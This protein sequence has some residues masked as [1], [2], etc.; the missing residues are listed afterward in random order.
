M[1][2][3]RTTAP[4]SFT[5]S[6]ASWQLPLGFAAELSSAE[7]PAPTSTMLGPHGGAT[8]VMVDRHG[9]VSPSDKAWSLDWR[10]RTGDG[11]ESAGDVRKTTQR[12]AGGCV[13]E[14]TMPTAVG[15]IHHRVA[16]AVAGGQPVVL[17]DIENAA[18]VAVAVALAVRPFSHRHSGV[19]AIT[20][21]V[22]GIEADGQSALRPLRPPLAVMAASDDDVLHQLPA[23][24]DTGTTHPQPA[25]SSAGCA[26][27]ALIWAVPHTATLRVWMPLSG[28]VPP[29]AAVPGIDDVIRGWDRHLS[30]LPNIVV[31]ETPVAEAIPAMARDLLCR[32]PAD[33]DVA[34]WM[35][36]LADLGY[37]REAVPGVRWL[38]DDE[39][40][41][42]VIHATGRLGQLGFQG[43]W[44]QDAL[45][46]LAKAA[47]AMVRGAT[48]QPM[49]GWGSAVVT[50]AAT[51]A[52]AIQQPDVADRL[53]KLASTVVASH[54]DAS[55]TRPLALAS[56]TWTWCGQE[57]AHDLG[58]TARVAAA[59]R[60]LVVSDGPGEIRLLSE[61]PVAWRGTNVEAHNVMCADGILSFGLRWHGPRPA[62]LWEFEPAQGAESSTFRLTVPGVSSD[63]V[64]TERAGEALLPDPGWPAPD[65]SS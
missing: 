1:I 14:T 10:V 13:I 17:V 2:F 48:T 43:E 47:H 34:A 52:D 63:W 62:L 16:V 11:W 58:E 37:G 57:H 28:T 65:G 60:Q 35:I 33:G 27:A 22:D 8:S 39:D 42:Q 54:G 40:P 64:G 31:E 6:P 49:A 53:R 51:V 23:E 21:S 12:L 20:A 26:N 55:A 19:S 50:S 46:P 45:T 59:L 29:G 15:P 41:A 5:G 4:A 30:S 9:W 25:S 24:S 18:N 36:A 32:T 44:Q 61:M 56:P 3:R 38:G 7:D